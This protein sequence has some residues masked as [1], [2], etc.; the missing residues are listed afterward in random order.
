MTVSSIVRIGPIDNKLISR[1]LRTAIVTFFKDNADESW[2]STIDND[3]ECDKNNDNL[4]TNSCIIIRNK[5]FCADV[6]LQ[7]FVTCNQQQQQ[8]DF[9]S[10]DKEDGIILVFD[11]LQCNPDRCNGSD[12]IT[13]DSL[14]SAHQQAIDNNSC[15]DIIRLCVGVS[16]VDVSPSEIRGKDHE[17]EY[18]RRV[19]WCLDNGYEYIEANLSKEGQQKGHGDR[20]K[21]GFAR[22]IEA[23]QGTVWSSAT[24]STTKTNELKDS[25]VN[26]K[27]MVQQ[28]KYNY[29]KSVN[30]I[31]NGKERTEVNLYQPPD[32]SLLLTRTI[33]EQQDGSS[34]SNSKNVDAVN[35]NPIKDSCTDVAFNLNV[36]DEL[37]GVHTPGMAQSQEDLEGEKMFEKMESVLKEASQIREASKS[38]V[39]SDDERRERAGE[40]A[41][42]LVNLMDQFGLDDD[43]DG[44]ISEGYG[45][46]DSGVVDNTAELK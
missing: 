46:D 30:E 6:I 20:D 26:G 16:L 5:Y 40:A 41:L 36:F 18:S 11:S 12:G 27:S 17:K 13:F 22:I 34:Y 14:R 4:E 8:Q 33:I 10:N 29:P 21:D 31:E 45:S 19:L 15:G 25:Y 32:S 44:D 7:D 35:D 42:A 28:N 43:D 38:G 2:Q 9:N 23:I 3:I 24:M 1:L 37:K 39:L